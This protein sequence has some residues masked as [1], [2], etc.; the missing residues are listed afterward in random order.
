MVRLLWED[1]VHR[2]SAWCIFNSRVTMPGYELE[3]QLC[4]AMKVQPLL[5]E[6]CELAGQHTEGESLQLILTRVAVLKH[7]S[8]CSKHIISLQQLVATH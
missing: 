8:G 7:L 2:S 6:G 4:L 5:E 3:E 1:V